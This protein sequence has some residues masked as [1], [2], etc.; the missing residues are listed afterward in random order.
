MYL[1]LGGIAFMAGQSMT[2][3]LFSTARLNSGKKEYT[4]LCIGD[5]VT[6]YGGINSY[7]RI[8]ERYLNSQSSTAHF[9]VIN[10]GILGRPS[11][12]LVGY[13]SIALDEYNPDFVTVMM[14]IADA[15]FRHRV[16]AN[17]IEKT[18]ITL[19][20]NIKTLRLAKRLIDPLRP[21]LKKRLDYDDTTGLWAKNK[22][23]DNAVVLEDNSA[24]I[25]GPQPDHYD[26]PLDVNYDAPQLLLAVTDPHPLTINSFQDAIEMVTGRG[27]KLFI[28]Q[29]P[30]M[31]IDT[32][33]SK[34]GQPKNV[35]Y[36]ENKDNFEKALASSPKQEYFTDLLTSVFGHCTPKG[37]LLM[38]TKLAAAILAS[39]H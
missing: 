19:L 11:I 36:V 26:T 7:P 20:K 17:F 2:D 28:M 32:L 18:K 1:R 5:S 25:V 30:L 15:S 37:N 13:L 12:N 27:K 35:I 31:S 3:Q 38:T 4:V 8:L 14:G 21:D 9:T 16:K 33:K 6:A 24:L 39:V 29:Y 10:K 23:K 34:L 22:T